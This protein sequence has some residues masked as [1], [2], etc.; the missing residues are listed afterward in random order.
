MAE[1]YILCINCRATFSED[2]IEGWGCPACGNKGVPGDTRK[3]STVTLTNHEWQILTIWADNWA[4]KVC[5]K[6]QSDGTDSVACIKAIIKEMSR[7]APEMSGLTMG[8]QIQELADE[9]GSDVEMHS[10][11]K[12]EIVKPAKRH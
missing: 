4:R 10:D 11:G 7:Q 3:K 6:D 5:A 1:K 9:F 2:E 8:E 12:R